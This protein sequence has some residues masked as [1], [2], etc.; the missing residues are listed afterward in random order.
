MKYIWQEKD[1]VVGTLFGSGA[2]NSLMQIVEVCKRGENFKKFHKCSIA[3]GALYGNP[4][5]AKEMV[6]NFNKP[7]NEGDERGSNYFIYNEKQI[8]R[9]LKYLR[10]SHYAPFKRFKEKG[11]E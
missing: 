9:I 6:E 4:M 7:L 11:D 10:S 8:D 5:T 2:N 1:I 3:T